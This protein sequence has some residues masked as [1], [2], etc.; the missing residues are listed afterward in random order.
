[1]SGVRP[2][3]FYWLQKV[4]DWFYKTSIRSPHWVW[5]HTMIRQQKLKRKIQR[6]CKLLRAV[7]LVFTI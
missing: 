3:N 1:M 6:S 4:A 5:R 2:V 7:L